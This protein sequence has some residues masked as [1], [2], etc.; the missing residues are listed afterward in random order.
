MHAVTLEQVHK[1]F[2]TV[3]AADAVTLAIEEGEFFALLGPSGSGKTTVLRLIAG[4]L[5]P[6]AGRIT[7]AGQPV[8]A[9]P[10]Y[11]REIGMV[12][13]N[14]ALFP[15]MTVYGNLA[16]GLQVRGA[17]RSE[18]RRRVQEMLEL[19]RLPGLENRRPHELSGGQ[20][21]RVALARALITRP[22]VVLLDEPL[23]ALDK[24][25]REE[26]QVEL[27]EIQRE[28]GTTAIFVTHDQEEALTLADRIAIMNHGRVEQVGTPA[29]VYERPRTAFVAGFLG[30][31]NFFAGRVTAV[32]AG[33]A[34]EVGQVGDAGQAGQPRQTGQSGQFGQDRQAG[35]GGQAATD[36]DGSGQA[37]TGAGGLGQV[38]T[39]YGF[40]VRTTQALPPVGQPVTLIVRPE[41][42]VLTP[43]PPGTVPPG[44]ENGFHGRVQQVVYSGKSIKYV[45]TAFGR[46]FQVLEQNRDVQPVQAGDPVWV[47]W[48]AAH[49]VVVEP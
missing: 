19:V 11:Q 17:P 30:D 45:V 48:S 23:A 18:I 24:R 5:Q 20:Q 7:I 35:E 43:A 44:L 26:M 40:V 12:F 3:V 27:K 16:F 36:V 47:S 28:V 15:H 42:V 21:Q 33:Q 31:A 13:Q 8:E 4:F 1:R 34:G 49:T 46:E 22:K 32:G 29:Q 14:Y 2:G 6:D 10:A 25:L 39:D 41:R 9:V 38:T 37:A